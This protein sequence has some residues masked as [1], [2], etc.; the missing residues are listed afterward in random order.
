MLLEEINMETRCEIKESAVLSK[1]LQMIAA[2]E[3]EQFN[4]I[5]KQDDKWIF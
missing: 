3:E 5:S 4:K 1:W 2:W